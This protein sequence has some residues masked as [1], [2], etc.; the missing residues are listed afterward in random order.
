MNL[1]RS[2]SVPTSFHLPMHKSNTPIQTNFAGKK[3]P[4]ES[5]TTTSLLQQPPRKYPSPSPSTSTLPMDY[6]LRMQVVTDNPKKLSKFDF[7]R[8]VP[9]GKDYAVYLQHNTLTF[10]PRTSSVPSATIS[11][12]NNNRNKRHMLFFCTM[13]KTSFFVVTDV[14]FYDH[15]ELCTNEERIRA[16]ASIFKQGWLSEIRN[17]I[18]PHHLPDP[19][20]ENI[21]FHPTHFFI[22]WN[23]FAKGS[24][25]I[26]YEIK[27]LEYGF[28]QTDV[29]KQTHRFI[30]ILNKKS[31]VKSTHD[32][33]LVYTLPKDQRIRIDVTKQ[34]KEEQDEEPDEPKKTKHEKEDFKTSV[35]TNKPYFNVVGY[36]HLDKQEESDE[37]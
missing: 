10:F 8:L 13:V 30:Y 6:H 15:M 5:N 24:L 16:L 37:E 2:A 32:T 4:I 31:F 26:P 12:S 1:P 21:T 25:H 29:T 7:I 3:R 33:M 9:K 20:F 17:K 19:H 22:E 28:Y 11:I 14:L 34:E 36:S 27:H 18:S 23:E 35:L